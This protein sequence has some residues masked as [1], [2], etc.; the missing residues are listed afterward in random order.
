MSRARGKLLYESG[1]ITYYLLDDDSLHFRTFAGEPEELTPLEAIQALTDHMEV[2][3]MVT[4]KQSYLDGFDCDDF[5][6]EYEHVKGKDK[7]TE[8]YDIVNK[9]L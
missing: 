1:T 7:L 9:M 3:L 2:A 4:H 5:R 6:Q 8:A